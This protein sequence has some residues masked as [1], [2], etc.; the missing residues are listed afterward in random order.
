[1]NASELTRRAGFY[2]PVEE[3]DA[4]GMIV[5]GWTLQFTCA[6]HIRYLRGS[7]AVMQA[8]LQSKAPA[9]VTIRDFAAARQIT[10]EW[11]VEID[12]RTFDLKED[13]RREDAMLAMLVE[14]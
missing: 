5:Q 12:D 8:R 14:D 2:E 10:S 9:V 6:A 7:E 4:D 1:M 3:V 11:R 13:P